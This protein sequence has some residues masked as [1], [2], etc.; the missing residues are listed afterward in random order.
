MDNVEARVQTTPHQK[1]QAIWLLN[2]L[3]R[4]A[5]AAL[6]ALS[7]QDNPSKERISS[8]AVIENINTRSQV[9]SWLSMFRNVITDVVGNSGMSGNMIAEKA[10]KYV[11]KNIES[12]ISLQ[13]T[14]VAVGVSVGYLSTLFKRSMDRVLWILSTVQRFSMHVVSWMKKS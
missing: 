7:G 11:L 5:S 12:H 6:A 10:R 8:I 2:E 14:A 4:E 3:N 9:M 1:S 13:E